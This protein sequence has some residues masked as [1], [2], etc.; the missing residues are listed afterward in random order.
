VQVGDHGRIK[1]LTGWQPEV[2]LEKT[3][4]DVLA[5]FSA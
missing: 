1:A 5:G 2:P 4:A 3:L